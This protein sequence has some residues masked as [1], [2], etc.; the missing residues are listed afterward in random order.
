MSDNLLQLG[1]A[2]VILYI[3]SM[4]IRNVL[5]FIRKLK[6]TDE[7]HPNR[8][9]EDAILPLFAR[10]TEILN[11]LKAI[12]GESAKALIRLELQTDTIHDSID[13]LRKT[14]HEIVGQSQQTG[15][16]TRQIHE[17]VT[18]P[19]LLPRT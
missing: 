11:E 10:Q 3:V 6:S 9:Y 13:A 17:V 14:N 1:V 7:D 5:G 16:L 2:V 18:R 4:I 8:R 12:S 19:A 15:M